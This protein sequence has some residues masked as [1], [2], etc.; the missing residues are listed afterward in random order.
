MDIQ[1]LND[2]IA[3]LNDLMGGMD[4]LNKPFRIILVGAHGT[5]KSTLAKKLSELL[6]LKV[7]ESV[8]REFMK[9]MKYIDDCGVIDKRM[10]KS[11]IESVKQNIL[12]SL[13]RWDFV[14]WLD[15]DVIMTRSPLDTL[16]YAKVDPA[17]DWVYKNN[18]TIMKE[19]EKFMNALKNSIFIYLPIEF[20]IEDDGC[21]PMDKQYQK[22]VDKAMR[23]VMHEFGIKP[24]VVTGAVKER[25]E[26]IIVKMVG[27]D[28]APMIMKG[29]ND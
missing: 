27:E 17:C 18:V 2:V 29:Y 8:A 24:L 7:V 16:A 3:K 1:K 22:D 6:D 11:K 26:Q 19:C 10:P 4:E 15:L 21:R 14:R 5:G 20:D 13:S 25:V 12:C 9:D 28:L 23:E